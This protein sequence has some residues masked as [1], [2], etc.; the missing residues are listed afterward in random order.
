MLNFIWSNAVQE[1]VMVVIQNVYFIIRTKKLADAAEIL[2][3]KLLME[4]KYTDSLFESSSQTLHY[5]SKFY[6]PRL[7]RDIYN[8][9]LP[10]LVIVGLVSD[11]DF[12]AHYNRNHFI[13]QP[14][15]VNRIRMLYKRMRTPRYGYTRNF[16]NN[17]YRKDYNTLLSQLNLFKG[18]KSVALI[19]EEWAN[20]YT[21]YA[22]KT[23]DG[24]IKPGAKTPSSCI[25]TGKLRFSISFAQLYSQS[26]NMILYYQ[27]V[28]F[29]DINQF[30]NVVT[31]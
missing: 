24:P 5:P 1:Q 15:N 2:I 29:I 21:L 4:K 23:T 7:R 12:G 25:F 22:F 13:F 11:K 17:Q 20:G 10:Y 14:F 6:N 8:G 28:G 31:A 16:T 18:D 9:T 30:K 3:R 27:S 26:I 19:F